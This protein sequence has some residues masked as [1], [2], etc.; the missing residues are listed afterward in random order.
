[1]GELTDDPSQLITL[2]VLF[3]AVVGE[4]EVIWGS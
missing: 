3:A 2:L 1:V 4:V